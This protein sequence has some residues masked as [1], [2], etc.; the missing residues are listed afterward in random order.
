M[1]LVSESLSDPY[2]PIFLSSLSF[3]K[4][5]PKRTKVLLMT[6]TKHFEYLSTSTDKK[7]PISETEAPG[8]YAQLL[9]E[10]EYPFVLSEN[11]MVAV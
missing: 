10:T 7:K 8:E 4:P 1:I 5:N 2:S 3:L 6:L 11:Y 9:E